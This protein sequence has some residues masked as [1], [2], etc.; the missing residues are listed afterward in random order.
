MN[1]TKVELGVTQQPGSSP[2]GEAQSFSFL[3]NALA[4]NTR[5]F[6]SLSSRAFLVNEGHWRDKNFD[7]VL[8]SKIYLI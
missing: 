5:I 1:Y 2:Q 8:L 3:W 4:D 6:S 7:Y